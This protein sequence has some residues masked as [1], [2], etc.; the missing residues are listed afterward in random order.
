MNKFIF[1]LAISFMAISCADQSDVTTTTGEDTITM[2]QTTP[3]TGMR[4]TQPD[5]AM[6]LGRDSLYRLSAME[7]RNILGQPVK[8]VENTDT[9]TGDVLKYKSTYTTLKSDGLSGLTSNLY[10]AF[11]RY[12]DTTYA[13]KIY[14]DLVQQNKNMPGLNIMPE[15]GDEGFYHSDN[16][17][18]QLVIFRK[19]NQLVRLKVNKITNTT[20]REA[21]QK[22]AGHIA[23]LL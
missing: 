7:A 18:F 15:L 2:P 8:L 14:S 6:Q 22:T 1:I 23:S 3:D 13:K 16:Q 17:N 5:T 9:S 19:N 10:Y 11:E 4:N 12:S 20:S 21:L